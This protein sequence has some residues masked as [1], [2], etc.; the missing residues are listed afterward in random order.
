MRM[1]TEQFRDVASRYR[2]HLAI[3]DGEERITYGELLE[4][5]GSIRAWLD[6]ALPM[7]PG[8]VIVASFSNTWQFV[9]CL[10]AV[11]ELGGILVPCN[12]QW[13]ASELRWLTTR[14]GIRGAIVEGP[15]RLEWDRISD[16]LPPE[17]VVSLTAVGARGD[18]IVALPERSWLPG[19]EEGPAVYLVTSGSTGVPK[20][21]PRSHRNLTAGSAAVGRALGVGPGNRVLSVV[22]FFHANGFHNCM[23]MPLMN[24]AALVMVRHFSPVA[25]A[26]LI[27][28]ERVDVMNAAPFIYGVLVD[29]VTDPSFFSTVERCICA[30][31]RMPVEIGRRWQAQVGARVRQ[32]YGLT[33][34][35]VIS[36]DCLT[37]EPPPDATG[38]FVGA[39][40]PGVEVRILGIDEHRR[41]DAATGEIAVRSPA[42]MSGY[43]GQPDWNREAFRDG[44]F[45]TGD[46]GYLGEDGGLY[47]TG[48]LRHVINVAGTKV[49]P[50]EVEQALERLPG[51]CGCHVDA[52]PDAR[53]GDIIRARIAVSSGFQITR[54][55]VIE[56]CRHRLAEYKLPR[57]IEFLE[58][59]SA[60]VAGK[61]PS[62]WNPDEP[63]LT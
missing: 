8:D 43:F 2:D 55:D 6:R 23:L 45:R 53:G 59:T 37:I 21:V 17:R 41:G 63:T 42:V 36:I 20:I 48:R 34:T 58:S 31:A 12:P 5:V 28:R 19:S 52:L 51:V 49:D 57:V 29:R 39:P 18:A 3:V 30:G 35:S 50:T 62:T 7:L 40:I 27:R 13:R 9:A 46:L 54:A 16:V 11:C 44:F 10:F 60:T 1:I 25:C 14:L 15:F 56:H 22:P 32:L 33:E 47:L 38:L 24:G 61:I 26:E 4:R